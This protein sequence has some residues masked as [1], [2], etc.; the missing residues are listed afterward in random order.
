MIYFVCF[1][2]TVV[3]RR[4][5]R[6]RE[7][8][9]VSSQFFSWKAEGDAYSLLFFFSFHQTFAALLHCSLS[10]KRKLKVL[11]VL[12]RALE[13]DPKSV[14][15]W[16]VYLHI[17]YMKE[18]DLGKDDM[19]LDAVHCSYYIFFFLLPFCLVIIEIFCLHLLPLS[20]EELIYK[21]VHIS[22]LAF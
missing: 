6:S 3:R 7:M 1:L 5:A 13:R 14:L 15:I 16:I 21:D 2:E 19:F 10:L 18:K 17:Y 20:L 4:F 8:R 22:T 12:S 11:S 9:R